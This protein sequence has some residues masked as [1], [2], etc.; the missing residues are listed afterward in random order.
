MLECVEPLRR[1]ASRRSAS[2][3]FYLKSLRNPVY[4]ASQTPSAL[5]LWVTM[6]SRK[7]AQIKDPMSSKAVVSSEAAK[8]VD[9]PCYFLSAHLALYIYMY[10]YTS[11]HIYCRRSPR[12]ENS[13]SRK[14]C[15]N[16]GLSLHYYPW[17][18][19]RTWEGRRYHTRF[20]STA[21]TQTSFW[22]SP[23]RPCG[24]A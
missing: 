2:V 9:P 16:W 10:I 24:R 8:W 5:S 14:T 19:A 1:G 11:S 12:P 20:E 17:K 21:S 6:A 18:V 3:Q 22:Y 23:S 7:R 15:S 4:Q 13:A